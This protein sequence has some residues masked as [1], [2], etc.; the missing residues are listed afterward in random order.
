M[1]HQSV[2]SSFVFLFTRQGLLLEGL[3]ACLLEWMMYIDRTQVDKE[4]Y[5]NSLTQLT[6]TTLSAI[7][8]GNIAECKLKEYDALPLEVSISKLPF[9]ILEM[10]QF[11]V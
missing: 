1:L 6:S 7:A 2:S 3:I 4:G 10:N 11:M 8:L 9:H 5:V